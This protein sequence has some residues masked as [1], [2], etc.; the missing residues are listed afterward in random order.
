MV[1]DEILPIRKQI[2]VIARGILK[3]GNRPSQASV[4]QH[5]GSSSSNTTITA[6]L[7]EFWAEIGTELK[8]SEKRPEIPEELFDLVMQLWGSAVSRA[9]EYAEARLEKAHDIEARAIDSQQQLKFELESLQKEHIQLQE[10]LSESKALH[11]KQHQASTELSALLSEAHKTIHEKDET[12]RQSIDQ[13]SQFRDQVDGRYHEKDNQITALNLQIKELIA[14]NKRLI[15][16]DLAS[17]HT[18]ANLEKFKGL[19]E[20][21]V[22]VSNE[23]KAQLEREQLAV[24]SLQDRFQL[25]QDKADELRDRFDTRMDTAL[26]EMKLD[27]NEHAKEKA[28]LTHQIQDL[29]KRLELMTAEH[30][31]LVE[32]LQ[33]CEFIEYTPDSGII[34]TSGVVS[35]TNN[36]TDK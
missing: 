1:Q 10:Q 34:L 25:A 12:I 2:K 15:N 17:R 35:S 32:E 33:N 11:K 36:S 8:E 27:R 20:N 9:D 5:L 16:S 3:E 26:N 18:I 31:T 29:N 28:K 7:Q 4:K 21:E 19:H 22:S 23:L 13:H 6:A 14:E 24:K 30:K